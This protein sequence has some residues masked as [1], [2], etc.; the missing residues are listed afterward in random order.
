CELESIRRMRE[1]VEPCEKSRTAAGRRHRPEGCP[2]LGV[3]ALEVQLAPLRREDGQLCRWTVGGRNI[4]ITFGSRVGRYHA[5]AA[6]RR[7]H[8]HNLTPIRR[9]F[10]TPAM[11]PDEPRTTPA[12][13]LI[14][15]HNEYVSRDHVEKG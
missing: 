13:M 2:A 7:R 14:A 8:E 9:P 6:V 4:Q 1:V 15:A 12:T 5:N 3:M 11:S 10:R